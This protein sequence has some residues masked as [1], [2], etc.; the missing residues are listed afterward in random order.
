VI[1]LNLAAKATA[2]MNA[3]SYVLPEDI[4]NVAID[5]LNHRILLSYEAEAEGITQVKFV[6]ELLSAQRI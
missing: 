1:A 2:L 6:E 3:R 5:V 4:K